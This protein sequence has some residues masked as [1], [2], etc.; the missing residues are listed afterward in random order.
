MS[1]TKLDK[2]VQLF[3]ILGPL[4]E[5]DRDFWVNGYSEDGNWRAWAIL[6]ARYEPVVLDARWVERPNAK[7]P[8][9]CTHHE[10]DA[11]LKLKWVAPNPLSL[12]DRL[13]RESDLT[14]GAGGPS[15]AG[16]SSNG[17]EEGRAEVFAPNDHGP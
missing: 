13:A 2:V 4:C 5:T 14:A 1:R 6:R 15:S 12:L 11:L 3:S 16:G 10:L 9:D 7:D 8:N 17:Q